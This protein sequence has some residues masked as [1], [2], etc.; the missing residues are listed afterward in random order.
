GIV[1]GYGA[2]DLYFSHP[3]QLNYYNWI[4][5]KA[6]GAYEKGFETAY[7]GEAVNEDVTNYLSSIVEPGDTV[8]VLALNELAFR[9]LRRW[10]KLPEKVDFSPDAPP[11]VYV[12]LQIRQG[13]MRNLEWSL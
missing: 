2:A 6:S 5:G 3:N 4:T 12:V 9:N 10:G 8:K 7:W 13:F 11:Y 1:T